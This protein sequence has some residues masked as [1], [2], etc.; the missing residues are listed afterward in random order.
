MYLFKKALNYSIFF[1]SLC[2]R[3]ILKMIKNKNRPS[4]V[5]TDLGVQAVINYE[6]IF[7][8]KQLNFR[9][10]NLYNNWCYSDTEHFC[11]WQHNHTSIVWHDAFCPDV[12]VLGYWSGLTFLFQ[13]NHQKRNEKQQMKINKCKKEQQKLLATHPRWNNSSFHQEYIFSSAQVLSYFESI[14]HHCCVVQGKA[15]IM[16]KKTLHFFFMF[17]GTRMWI[18]CTQ[19]NHFNISAWTNG[20]FMFTEN[21]SPF[22]NVEPLLVE[23]QQQNVRKL[24]KKRCFYFCSFCFIPSNPVNS[25][26]HAQQGC[27]D[28][29]FI[30]EICPISG[31]KRVSD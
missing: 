14:M 17:R 9:T 23:P 10:N 16:K 19:W 31:K 7:I 25:L 15:E 1:F 2:S 6:V 26:E 24:W 5:N 22:L 27:P 12:V 13:R 29:I 4:L 18:P 20:D 21:L 11:T 30:S 3:C 8:K 28:P